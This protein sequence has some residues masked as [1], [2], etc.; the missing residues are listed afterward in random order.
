MQLMKTQTKFAMGI[1][2]SIS[3]WFGLQTWLTQSAIHA[4]SALAFNTQRFIIAALVLGGIC[5]VTRVRFTKRAVRGGAIIGLFFSITIGL[6]SQALAYGAAGRVSFFISLFVAFM[7][8]LAYFVRSEKL[9]PAA[10][11]G[12]VIMLLGAQQLLGL[13]NNGSA[14]DV[15][16]ILCAAASAV[17]LL[18]VR[19]Y[20][21]EDWRVSCFINVTVIA[22]VSLAGSV[23]TEQTQFSLQ[24]NVLLPAVISALIGSVGCTVMM[25]WCGRHLSSAVLGVLS[26]L[27]APFSVIWGVI[28]YQDGLVSP[29]LL[30]YLLIGI[31]AFFALTA[32]MLP[33]SVRLVDR[34]VPAP[35]NSLS[36]D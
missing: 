3:A 6:E 5:L 17:T 4:S 25:M 20:A 10:I 26:F 32:G 2:F 7:P 8:F 22:L 29:S 24:I 19:H 30:A 13:Q 31:G 33:F 36:T 28:L 1:M 12:S 34:L 18:L 11:V 23:M 35:V 15:Y 27:E 9:Y 14:G 16:G 21:G